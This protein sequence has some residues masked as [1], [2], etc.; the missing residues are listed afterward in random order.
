[1]R[2]SLS[3]LALAT[4]GLVVLAS[5]GS[6]SGLTPTTEA[7]TTAVGDRVVTIGVISPQEAGLVDFGR[8]PDRPENAFF[9]AA[10]IEGGA[11]GVNAT[12]E[13]A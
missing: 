3:A 10:M 7:A 8:D 12:R 2:R 11:A 5:C 4:A 13:L 6:K 9:H 1:M